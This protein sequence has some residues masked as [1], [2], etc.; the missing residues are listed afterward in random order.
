MSRGV[1]LTL[2]DYRRINAAFLQAIGKSRKE[3]VSTFPCKVLGTDVKGY[4]TCK[5]I[6]PLWMH[7]GAPETTPCTRLW[8]VGFKH[9]FWITFYKCWLEIMSKT[10]EDARSKLESWEDFIRLDNLLSPDEEEQERQPSEA[11]SRV[12]RKMEEWEDED[13]RVDTD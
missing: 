4:G 10:F 5:L 6:C 9:D 1:Y 2:P 12:M 7:Y 11:F 8:K 3:G 13:K